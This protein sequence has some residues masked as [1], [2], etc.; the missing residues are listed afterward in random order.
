MAIYTI[1]EAGHEALGSDHLEYYS[2]FFSNMNRVRLE[3]CV[4][5]QL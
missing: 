3:H 5:E 1:R 4:N 2:H